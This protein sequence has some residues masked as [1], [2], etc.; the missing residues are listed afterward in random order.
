[1]KYLLALTALGSFAAVLFAQEGEWTQAELEA[2][3]ASILKDLDQM[4]GESFLRPVEVKLASK[5]D[6]LEYVLQRSE[7]TYPPE[8]MAADET[9]GKMLG[10]LAP[11]LDLMQTTLALLESQVGGFYDPASESF[12]LMEQFPKGIAAAI[13]SHELDHALDDQL[14]D[15]DGTLE[16]FMEVTDRA[17]AFWCVVE[18]SGQNVGTMWV[19][20]NMDRVDLESFATFQ[21]ETQHGLDEAPQWLWKP[22]LAAYLQGSS[23][24]V[25]KSGVLAGSTVPAKS[26]DIRTAF[27]SPPRSTEQ[28]LHPEKYWEPEHADEP[29]EVGFDTSALPAG[30][31]VLREDVLGELLLAIVTTT[32]AERASL[33]LSDPAAMLGMRF[34]NELASGWGG[35][36]VILLANEEARVM[37]LVTVWDTE[38]DAAEFYGGMTHLVPNIRAAVNQLNP[39]R[40]TKA[41]VTLE[42]AGEREVV[43]TSYYGVERKALRKILPA[44]RW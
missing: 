21:A 3:T 29:L 7:E 44:V 38:R 35:D 20:G 19:L 6:L 22:L 2:E 26:A 4:R 5:Q 13:L 18:G 1:M 32:P 27:E 36:R 43:L 37:R 10:V 16:E 23:F 24:L 9:I 8:R 42:Y 11:E 34:T 12:S 39:G 30:W 14:F 25:R 15:I 41:D 40:K 28:V 17:A 33:D 31:E